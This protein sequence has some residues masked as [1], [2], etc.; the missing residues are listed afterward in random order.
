MRETLLL[1]ETL[2]GSPKEVRASDVFLE[3]RAEVMDA[4]I[5]HYA[6][7][8]AARVFAQVEEMA[9]RHIAGSERLATLERTF[10]YLR[11]Q[12]LELAPAVPLLFGEPIGKIPSS[13]PFRSETL[14]KPLLLFD[15]SGSKT[16]RW[17]E[18]G[19][20]QYGPFDQRSFSPK[21]LRVAVICQ[22][23]FEGQVDNFLAKFFDGM[24]DITV[25]NRKP[26]A[27]GFI[28]RFGLERPNIR[29]FTIDG[30][31]AKHYSS[32]CRR[33]LE[34]ATDD[35]RPWDLVLVQIDRDFRDLP[36]P[37]NPYYITRA[38]FLK[39]RIPVQH[40]TLDTI[41]FLDGQLVF[42]VN[43]MSVAT[44]AKVGGIPWLLKAQPTVAHELIIGLGS[45]TTKTSR[46]GS[47]E[48]MVGITTMFRSDGRYILDDRT[49]A[50]PYSEY[51]D[52][53]FKSLKRSIEK[54]RDEDNWRSTDAVRL[55]FHVFKQMADDEAAAVDQ[56][57][58][59]LGFSDVKYAFVHLVDYHPFVIF[60]ET[61]QGVGRSKKGVFAPE[62]GTIVHLNRYESLVSFV[63]AK[64]V[65]DAKHGMPIPTLLRLHHR[66]T[67]TDMTYITRQAFD[68]SCHSWRMLFPAPLPITVHY[69]ELIAKQLA[70]LQ[71]VPSWDP[72]I[73]LGQVS[74]TKWFL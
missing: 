48:R 59:E 5:Q 41:R 23:V 47:G 12:N 64:E 1:D 62:R 50:V 14:E 60:D 13:W 9:A 33:V 56:L 74:R 73:M 69:S 38:A 2:D 66:S 42:A 65:K 30:N 61:N 16:S 28:R 35:G 70:G 20:D 45:Q 57:I 52:A 72:D 29:T 32:G 10:A 53:L 11:K 17:N 34:G 44:Y 49:T 43:N 36:S 3:P 6:G 4:C 58:T 22:S 46:F 63:G 39:H 67:F 37:T 7:G 31:S 68:F 15:P 25:G 51:R 54:V 26:Y 8:K 27:K 19:L 40:I 21:S 71:E 18:G 55:I 24:P